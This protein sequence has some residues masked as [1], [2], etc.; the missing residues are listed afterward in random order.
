MDMEPIGAAAGIAQISR[1]A[2]KLGSYIYTVY[3]GTKTIDESVQ[4][5]ALEV[6]GLA[7]TCDLVH[8]E[9]GT[10]LTNS[11]SGS[12]ASRYDKDGRLRRCIDHQVAQCKNT[13]GELETVVETLWPRKNSF[14][15]RASKQVNLQNSQEQMT[16]IMQR[17]RS[18]TDALHTILLVVNIRVAHIAPDHATQ[19]LPGKLDELRQMLKNIESKL[20]GSHSRSE[21]LGDDESTLI[22]LARDTLRGGKTLYEASVAGS[23]FGAET[24]DFFMGYEQAASSNKSVAEW[25]TAVTTLR[26]ESREGH[27]S[28]NAPSVFSDDGKD[29]AATGSTSGVGPLTVLADDVDYD[30]DDEQVELAQAALDLGNKAFDAEK[31]VFASRLLHI[32]LKLLTKLPHKH[33]RAEGIFELQYR[34]AVCSY[35]TGNVDQAE[36]ALESLSQHTPI[37][38]VQGIELCNARHLLSRIYIERNNFHA[39]REACDST[40][41]ARS[42]LLGKQHEALYES[43]ALMSRIYCLLNDDVMSE[44]YAERIPDARRAALLD[45]VSTLGISNLPLE[46]G[47]EPSMPIEIGLRRSNTYASQSSALQQLEAS[48]SQHLGRNSSISSLSPD[49][50]AYGVSP[51]ANP[52]SLESAKPIRTNSLGSPAKMFDTSQLWT[53]VEASPSVV[54]KASIPATIKPGAAVTPQRPQR[55]SS[56]PTIAVSSASSDNSKSSTSTHRTSIISLETHAEEKHLP[57]Q[58]PVQAGSSSGPMPRSD[59]EAINHQEVQDRADAQF[60]RGHLLRESRKGSRLGQRTILW[61]HAAEQP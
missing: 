32:S 45:A 33:K 61:I 17:I 56:A 57:I 3:Q 49:V 47:P 5:L 55:W 52:Q 21:Y 6:N 10:V 29:A 18:H 60:G 14:F 19:Q 40:L 43:M 35:H 38:D 42:R 34:L 16:E 37:S 13:L 24:A 59:R 25:V 4:S 23:V 8:N 50:S 26:T 22:N 53:S 51:T 39:A 27:F 36:A 28:D 11:G 12:T 46:T 1:S 48:P 31:W 2:W 41:K 44:L 9:L 20:D 30:S 58:T 7:S 54:S 15:E